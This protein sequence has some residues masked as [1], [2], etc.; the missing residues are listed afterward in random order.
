[1]RNKSKT[2]LSTGLARTSV[3]AIIYD[4]FLR[5]AHRTLLHTKIEENWDITEYIAIPHT[6]MKWENP[7]FNAGFT[8]L[9]EWNITEYQAVFVPLQPGYS[10]ISEP[11]EIST[12]TSTSHTIEPWEEDGRG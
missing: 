10:S 12:Y 11:W 5:R 4:D 8:S 9:E 3:S 6:N 2:G 7:L 1:M